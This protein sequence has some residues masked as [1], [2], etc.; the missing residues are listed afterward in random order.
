MT[1]IKSHRR[2]PTR[3][4]SVSSGAERLI[5]GQY[6]NIVKVTPSNQTLILASER[7]TSGAKSSTALDQAVTAASKGGTLKRVTIVAGAP[8]S[9]VVYVSADYATLQDASASHEQSAAVASSGVAARNVGLAAFSAGTSAAFGD[10]HQNTGG[11]QI[12]AF[13]SPVEQ[14]AQTQRRA[15]GASQAALIDVLA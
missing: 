15:S 3:Y 11:S 12:S 2:P 14:Y 9:S 5:G 1:G 10:S 4:F 7:R 8:N 13:L 6:I